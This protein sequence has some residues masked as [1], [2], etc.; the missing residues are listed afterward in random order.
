MYISYLV[1]SLLCVALYTIVMILLTSMCSWQRMLQVRCGGSLFL[2][3]GG[4]FGYFPK[5]KY[6]VF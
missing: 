3:I 6:G 4:A 5:V 2:G 1:L